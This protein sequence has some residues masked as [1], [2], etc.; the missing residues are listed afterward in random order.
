MEKNT[1]YERIINDFNERGEL[2]EGTHSLINFAAK[3]YP[4]DFEAFCEIVEAITA[5]K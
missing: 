5:E 2:Y 3:Y 4:D 1:M